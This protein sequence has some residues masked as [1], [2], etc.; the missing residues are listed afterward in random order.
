ML[1]PS[2]KPNCRNTCRDSPLCGVIPIKIHLKINIAFLRNLL[3][4]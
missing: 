2:S 3:A 4:Y 1:S